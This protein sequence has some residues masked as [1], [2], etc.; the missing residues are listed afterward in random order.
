VYA[1]SRKPNDALDDAFASAVPDDEVVF[2]LP[3]TR[4]W[5]RQAMLRRGGRSGPADARVAGE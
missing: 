5:M 2:E 3:V 4:M 1:Q